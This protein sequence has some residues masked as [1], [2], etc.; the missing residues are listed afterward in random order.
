MGLIERAQGHLPRWQVDATRRSSR[1]SRS[2]SPWWSWRWP[3]RWRCRASR[4]SPARGCGRRPASS[5]L[6][7]GPCTPRRRSAAGPAA[8]PSIWTRGPTGRSAPRARRA[9]PRSRRR[10][11]RASA[12]RRLKKEQDEQSACA[13][14]QGQPHRGPARGQDRLLRPYEDGRAPVTLPD[15]VSFAWIWVQ[16]QAEKY[17]AGDAFLYFFPQGNTEHAMIALKR[18]D[19]DLITVEMQPA[20]RHG[21]S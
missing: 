9:S 13:T 17:I 21:A 8:W 5:L 2:A 12:T 14:C 15:G 1:C 6:R 11:E 20:H 19:D 7:C 3:S 4:R 18:G 16:H 10:S